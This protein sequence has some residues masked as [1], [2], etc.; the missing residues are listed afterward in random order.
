MFGVVLTERDLVLLICIAAATRLGPRQSQH[1]GPHSILIVFV[2]FAAVRGIVAVAEHGKHGVFVDLQGL[3]YLALLPGIVRYGAVFGWEAIARFL[4]RA[5]YCAAGISILLYLGVLAHLIRADGAS[6]LGVVTLSPR[7]SRPGGEILI[8][9]AIVASPI[10][11]RL[12]SKAEY[13]VGWLLLMGELICSQTLTLVIAT[14][15]GSAF[16]LVIT[17][18]RGP[19]GVSKILPLLSG[20][21]IAICCLAA[22]RAIAPDPYRT[23]TAR[24]NFD[25]R[26]Q[27]DTVTYRKLEQADVERKW[28]HG[29]SSDQLVGPGPGSQI[30]FSLHGL[31]IRKNDT[32]DSFLTIGLK[33]GYIGFGF[34]IAT[35]GGLIVA[36]ARRG[37]VGASVAS[38]V[39]ATAVTSTTSPLLT[40]KSGWAFLAFL[41]SLCSLMGRSRGAVQTLTESDRTRFSRGNIVRST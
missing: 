27:T 36:F 4:V 6:V 35:I 16:Y 14:L 19:G 31:L 9:F 5:A 41:V 15:V 38:G 28:L 12:G 34:Y 23:L 8:P 3:L 39:V 24:F 1:S 17:L 10:R 18:V 22:F 32:H 37:E 33:F 30:E 29:S 13:R 20:L 25:Q 2:W 11:Q 7:L 26:V 21:V 40:Y